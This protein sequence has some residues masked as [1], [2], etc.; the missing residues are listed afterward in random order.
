MNC[1]STTINEIDLRNE[2]PCRI[3]SDNGLQ[4]VQAVT[5]KVTFGLDITQSF[6]PEIEILKQICIQIG[7]NL[8]ARHM[9]LEITQHPF[10]YEQFP[11]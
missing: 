5:Q 7:E 8:H 3:I 9:A 6:T 10:C 2:L 1:D 11:N 4:F